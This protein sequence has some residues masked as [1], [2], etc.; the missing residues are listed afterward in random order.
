[1]GVPQSEDVTREE[2]AL[3]LDVVTVGGAKMDT[4]GEWTIDD[5]AKEDYGLDED[6]CRAYF[7]AM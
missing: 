3:D 7:K 6:T 1:M 2:V 5:L 4:D